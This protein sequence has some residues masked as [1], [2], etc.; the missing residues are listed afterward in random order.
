MQALC[1]RLGTEQSIKTK[2]LILQRL[3]QTIIIQNKYTII[4]QCGTVGWGLG[5]AFSPRRERL[6]ELPFIFSWCFHISDKSKLV[7]F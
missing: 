4:T 2:S 1:Q 3:E 7:I 6:L 5:C